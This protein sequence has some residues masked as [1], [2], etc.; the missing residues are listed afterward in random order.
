MLNGFRGDNWIAFYGDPDSAMVQT[1]SDQFKMEIGS[2]Y[3]FYTAEFEAAR[4]EPLSQR[5]RR[6]EDLIGPEP[7]RG[8]KCSADT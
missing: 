1:Q 6:N 8:W 4:R 3:G 2:T 5:E 7:S